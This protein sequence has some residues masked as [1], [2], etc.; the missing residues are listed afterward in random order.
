MVMI[1]DAPEKFQGASLGDHDVN[2]KTGCGA[3]SVT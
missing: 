3:A 1:V 2:G